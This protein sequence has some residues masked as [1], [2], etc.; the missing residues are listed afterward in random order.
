MSPIRGEIDFMVNNTLIEMKT[1]PDD[2]CTFPNVCQTLMYAHLLQKKNI[3]IDKII[4]LN[5]WD[6][7]MDTFDIKEFNLKK[8]RKILYNVDKKNQ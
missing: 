2:A 1:T 5:L 4:I 7:T 8:F 3:V 6:G